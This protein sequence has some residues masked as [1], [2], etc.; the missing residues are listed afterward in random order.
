MRKVQ[1]LFEKREVVGARLEKI[2]KQRAIT[3]KGFCKEMGISRPTLDKLIAGEVTS[4][5][6]FVS[7]ME[8][9]LRVLDMEAE[10]ILG[11][12]PNPHTKVITF[13]KM[14][15][16]QAADIAEK[17]GIQQERLREIERGELAT[18]AELRD[19]AHCLGVGVR[20]LKGA[21]VFMPA[22]EENQAA[23]CDETELIH[24]NQHWGYLGVLL[25]NRSDYLWYPI[26]TGAYHMIH[27]MTNRLHWVIPCMNNRLLY[28]NMEHVR[29]ITLCDAKRNHPMDLTGRPVS[30]SACIA[31]AAYEAL[32][33][34][35]A[36][37]KDEEHSAG[38]FSA[39]FLQM[40]E[41]LVVRMKWRKSAPAEHN[42]RMILREQ[43]GREMRLLLDCN[44]SM[45]FLLKLKDCYARSS[46]PQMEQFQAIKGAGGVEIMFKMTHVAMLELPLAKAEE[47]ICQ[48]IKQE[49]F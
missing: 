49:S 40:M 21:C 18:D 46:D 27:Q 37:L 7:H 39:A 41:D 23:L 6:C 36:Y 43:D 22:I 4:Q 31:P 45:G 8:K 26:T 35:F 44:G 38:L 32:D 9:A 2:L 1:E 11:T 30:E 34:Y 33:D 5:R 17:T 10:Q 47:A 20:H 42:G 25:A 13:R 3:K 14:L 24:A 28:L 16:Y 48:K 29:R 15:H 19:I 12:I